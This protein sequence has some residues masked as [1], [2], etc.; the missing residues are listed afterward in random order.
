MLLYLEE[1]DDNMAT[2]GGRVI[3]NCVVHSNLVHSLTWLHTSRN[4][5]TA[6]ENGQDSQILMTT[7]N[8]SNV[9]IHF[10]TINS[11]EFSDAGN[12]TCV[13]MFEVDSIS[14]STYLSVSGKFNSK[15]LNYGD[16]HLY[17][18]L[19]IVPVEVQVHGSNTVTEFESLVISCKAA[20][21]PLPAVQ[22]YRN[23]E[24]L[25]VLSRNPGARISISTEVHMEGDSVP[26]VMSQLHIVRMTSHDS[27]T[28]Q[29][30]AENGYLLRKGNIS[31]TVSS[32]LQPELS[33]SMECHIRHN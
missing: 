6:V 3:F 8:M 19:H 22:W 33:I 11:V 4:V 15:C 12:Y 30:S 27:G 13:A 16:Y 20:G 23:G 25:D 31:V 18:Y 32:K 10:L 26:F 17:I 1:P 5:T 29:C 7:S 24:N 2:H 9:T 28:Y 21:H 14:L